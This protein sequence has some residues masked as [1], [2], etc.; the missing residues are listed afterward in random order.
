MS[1]TRAEV[2]LPSGNES[3]QPPNLHICITSSLFNLLAAL[4]L[5]LVSCSSTHVILVT[6]NQSFL[7]VC[8][9]LSLEPAPCWVSLSLTHLLLHLSLRLPLLIHHSRPNSQTLFTS[10]LKPTC[11]THSSHCALFSYLRADSTDYHLDRIFWAIL[12]FVFSSFPYFFLLLVLCSRLSWLA[13]SFWVHVNILIL[14]YH[15]RSLYGTD[16]VQVTPLRR[17]LASSP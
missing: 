16:M 12:I 5:S 1:C 6:D 4:A 14:L 17:T 9:T 13:V 7:S 8:F 3:W 11:F 10:N 2:I 15:I